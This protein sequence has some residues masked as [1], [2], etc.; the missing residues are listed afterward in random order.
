M[1]VIPIRK[2]KMFSK[3]RSW[4]FLY[5][6][7]P[8]GFWWN[9]WRKSLTAIAQECYKIYWT[10]SGG[11][12]PQNS[13]CTTTYRSSRK[14]NEQDI[15]GTAGDVTRNSFMMCS[16]GPLHTKKQGFDNKVEP[17]Y[18]CIVVIE[19]VAQKSDW[20]LWR[21]VIEGQRNPCK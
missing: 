16:C 15:R 19:D 9:A 6:E 2:N 17:I 14:P 3:Q 13:S 4:R 11:D 1:D 18:D 21:V 12:I 5:M 8:N 20:R 7:A 10:N